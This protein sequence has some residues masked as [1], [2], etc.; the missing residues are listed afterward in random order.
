MKQ[1]LYLLLLFA[2]LQLISLETLAQM[3]G[4][5]PNPSLT[6]ASSKNKKQKKNTSASHHWVARAFG[7]NISIAKMERDSR[8]KLEAARLRDRKREQESGVAEFFNKR[9]V[10]NPKK[11]LKEAQRREREKEK[12]S[13][14]AA[15]FDEEH[16]AN[17][18]KSLREAK[19]RDR[20]REK[21]SGVNQYF[22][23]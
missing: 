16:Q 7:E 13:G 22:K 11:A 2:G 8:K 19:K 20:K 3:G 6:K 9:H 18:K 5:A 14:V 23:D 15:F 4:Y 21:N 12:Y 10:S 1:L 17:P